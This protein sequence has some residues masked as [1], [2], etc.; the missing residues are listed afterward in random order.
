MAD[1]EFIAKVLFALVAA[2]PNANV[3]KETMAVYVSDLSDI[4]NEI[5]DAACTYCR[6]TS[7]WFPTIAELRE[8]S[9]KLQTGSDSLPPAGEAWGEVL[10]IIGRLGYFEQ[11]V[12][13]NPVAAKTV[14]AMGW[15]NIAEG[16]NR[17]A[18]RAR[19]IELYNTYATRTLEQAKLPPA[20]RQ[21]NPALEAMRTLAAK[22]L[23]GGT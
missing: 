3:G 8:A 4:P 19:F 16:D 23:T 2:Y 22:R 10:R 9:A 18:D 21:G 12:F 1:R 13:D 17:T 5:L 14:A 11:P 20:L 7:K 15:K 6:T